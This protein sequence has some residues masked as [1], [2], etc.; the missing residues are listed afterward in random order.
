MQRSINSGIQRRAPMV[1]LLVVS[2]V[3]LFWSLAEISTDLAE[4]KGGTLAPSVAA[5]IWLACY[6]FTSY[7]A[8]GTPYLF[9]SAYIFC[10]FVFHFGLLIQ[11][12]FGFVTMYN[13]DWLGAW[14]FR[15]GWYADLALA[16][17]GTGFSAYTLKNP[18]RNVPPLDIAYGV[19]R[20][21]LAWL[22]QQGL[23]LL[24]AAALL[25]VATILMKGNILGFTRMELLFSGDTRLTGVFS[26]FAPAAVTAMVV[27]SQTRA[28][29][30]LAYV[31]A[32]L[33]FLLFLLLGQRSTAMFPLMVGVVVWAK[34]GR[35]INPMVAGA[36]IVATLL[37]IPVVGYLRTLGTYGEITNGAAI[38]IASE[39]SEIAA[40]FRE[41][42]GSIG[43]LIYTLKLIP[44]EESY[45]YGNSYLDYMGYLIPNLGL[46]PDLSHTREDARI[47]SQ[48]TKQA[49]W[50]LR[51]GDWASF[52]MIRDQFEKGGGAGFS[53]VAEPYFN[54]GLA[55]VLIFFVSLGLFLGSL[56]CK[57]LLL[58]RNWLLFGAL[59]FWSLV[60]TVRNDFGTFV[61]PA[62]F[63]LIALGIWKFVRRFV[64]LGP[65]AYTP[66]P[67]VSRRP[68]RLGI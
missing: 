6:L 56:D 9:A 26:M 65:F 39:H 58:N 13:R 28:Q 31:A 38:S 42:G 62:A 18:G 11:D 37:V 25:L 49:L 27:A 68:F 57:A 24:L 30:R 1:L 64:P 20:Q 66:E 16:C 17:I 61:K 59:M 45:R 8:F 67:S 33:T 47:N 15:A 54:F 10:L 7:L 14:V 21:N 12:G 29:R 55:G 46:S 22:Y 35:K 53:A 48:P 51:P 36:A 4:L 32:V 3:V 5:L 23:G 43:P 2:F 19:A 41:M 40:A 63:I 52:H 34:T 44:A 50:N 60:N